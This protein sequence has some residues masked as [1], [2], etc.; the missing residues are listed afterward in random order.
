MK[1]ESRHQGEAQL[2]EGG[3]A[4]QSDAIDGES[5]RDEASQP[6]GG[7][8]RVLYWLRPLVPL[9]CAVGVGKLFWAVIGEPAA[10]YYL[11]SLNAV[12]FF[13]ALYLTFK[14]SN[15]PSTGILH[16]WAGN[17]MFFSLTQSL[18][19]VGLFATA[20]AGVPTKYHDVEALRSFL[21]YVPSVG[22]HAWMHVVN[23]MIVAPTIVTWIS[24]APVYLLRRRRFMR[25]E[26][27][28]TP[29]GSPEVMGKVRPSLPPD[30]DRR[31]PPTGGRA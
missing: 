30:S 8:A 15:D 2:L 6:S 3:S 29:L 11:H 7:M 9:A 21:G 12:A 18:Y 27:S 24:C 23:W 16:V 20:A 4:D 14:A 10:L 22:A 5:S 13:A 1:T 25:R 19:L 26:I 28:Q 31:S 17:L